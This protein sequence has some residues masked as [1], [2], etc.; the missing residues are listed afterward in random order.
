LH[1]DQAKRKRISP[2]EAGRRPGQLYDP[3]LARKRSELALMLSLILS[4]RKR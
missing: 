4:A 1:Q 3:Y 2:I